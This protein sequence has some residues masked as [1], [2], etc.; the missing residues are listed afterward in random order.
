VFAL[1]HVILDPGAA[2]AIPGLMLLGLISAWR[3]AETGNL[4]QSFFLHAGFNLWA[5][6]FL[7]T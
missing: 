5:A 4:S 1:V 2:F 7:L 6:I 3:A